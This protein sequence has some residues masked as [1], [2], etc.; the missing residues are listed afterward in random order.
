MPEWM[1]NSEYSNNFV[2]STRVRLARNVKN[3]PFPNK[4]RS[5]AEIQHIVDIAKKSFLINSDFKFIDFSKISNIEKL[6]L[7]EKY[8][9]SHEFSKR[10]YSGLI[11]SRD[12][13]LSIMVME[14][15]HF[16]LQCILP[17]LNIEKAHKLVDEMDN[18]LAKNA[19]YAFIDKLGYL[20]ACPTN[21]GTGMRVSVM[22]N[23]PGLNLS[24]DIKQVV[25]KLKRIG[26]TCRGAFGEGS[27]SLG[28]LFQISNEVTLGYSEQEILDNMI[29][30]TDEIIA[31]EQEVGKKLYEFNPSLIE[32]KIFRAYAV[33]KNARIISSKEM[34]QCISYVNMGVSLG[35]IDGINME[36]LYSLVIDTRPAS[37]IANEK[38]L[39]DDK[40]RDIK[41]ANIVRNNIN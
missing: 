1:K 28:D 33:L 9:V 35:L 38:E 15:D 29:Q 26:Q 41:R 23:L 20:S 32:D 25:K 30:T 36:K 10:N 19:E 24:G 34:L 3:I 39:A 18:M 11:L 31:M 5:H 16:R 8:L 37:L 17:S 7:Y 21:I 27:N 4:M 14:E 6:K 12:E 13:K 2:V 22:M 40:V